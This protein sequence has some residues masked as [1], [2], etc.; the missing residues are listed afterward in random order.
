MK[1]GALIMRDDDAYAVY[2]GVL[3]LI[4]EIESGGACLFLFAVHM[5]SKKISSGFYE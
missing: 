2:M 4:R 3:L 5:V 1:T